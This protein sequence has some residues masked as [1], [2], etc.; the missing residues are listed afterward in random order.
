MRYQLRH[1]S[2]VCEMRTRDRVL[3]EVPTKTQ[4]FLLSIGE[5]ALNG[6]SGATE[7]RKFCVLSR[8]PQIPGAERKAVPSPPR[9]T[10]ASSAVR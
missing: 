4:K 8:D 1:A 10:P 2:G 9:L 7:R 6:P 3:G 5:T